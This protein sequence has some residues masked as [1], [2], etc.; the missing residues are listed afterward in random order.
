MNTIINICNGPHYNWAFS[1]KDISE[2]QKTEV[3][4]FFPEPLWEHKKV[5][6]C[7]AFGFFVRLNFLE[8][9]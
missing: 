1:Y 6:F 9:F 2:G 4:G 8:Q 5:L 7:F 3:F